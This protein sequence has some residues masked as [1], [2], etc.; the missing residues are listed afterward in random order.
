MLLMALIVGPTSQL[1]CM[2]RG[3]ITGLV[4]QAEELIVGQ[5][6]TEL[7]EQGDELLGY[8]R[9]TGPYDLEETRQL[10]KYCAGVNFIVPTILNF[11]EFSSLKKRA[12]WNF[13]TF[14]ALVAINEAG[15]RIMINVN[16][17]RSGKLRIKYS[18]TAHMTLVPTAFCAGIFG[19]FSARQVII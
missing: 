11:I 2:N 4:E 14:A 15:R 10:F 12:L 16:K 5:T 19:G 9:D 18:P 8:R 17:T 1:F 6:I 3:T 13:G 7:V